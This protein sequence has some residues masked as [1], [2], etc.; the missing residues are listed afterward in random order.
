MHPSLYRIRIWSA[1]RPWQK[2]YK[3]CSANL[4]ESTG[5]VIVKQAK[6]SPERTSQCVSGLQ[7]YHEIRKIPI[8][9][10]WIGIFLWRAM[11]DSNARPSESEAADF[12]LNIA[13]LQ[14]VQRYSFS[15]TSIIFLFSPCQILG[16]L[17]DRVAQA[18]FSRDLQTV[19]LR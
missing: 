9:Q 8:H 19:F 18:N 4:P 10:E 16:P 3:A 15:F 14:G 6:R 2:S 5:C 11:R 7:Q 17:A 12:L 1:I 13:Y